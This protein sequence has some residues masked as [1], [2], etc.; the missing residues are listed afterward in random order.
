MTA[1]WS[2]MTFHKDQQCS[3]ARQ[4]LPAHAMEEVNWRNPTQHSTSHIT[5]PCLAMMMSALQQKIFT[6]SCTWE[7][8]SC[9]HG[10]R[11]KGAVREDKGE[12]ITR[13]DNKK[14]KIKNW[15]QNSKPL[16]KTLTDSI[17][18][19]SEWWNMDDWDD[20]M[21]SSTNAALYKLTHPAKH[22]HLAYS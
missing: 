8:F 3:H 16:M 10:R 20:I 18:L 21:V 7:I 13:G 4:W 5:A 17:N 9:C 6:C 22:I 15:P 19:L 1:P 2:T 12:D 14:I 11:Q